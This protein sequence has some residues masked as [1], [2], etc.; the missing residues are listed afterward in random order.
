MCCR[1][2]QQQIGMKDQILIFFIKPT[3]NCTRTAI[4]LSSL[5][6]FQFSSRSIKV[7]HIFIHNSCHRYRKISFS[8]NALTRKFKKIS[9]SS[10]LLSVCP[11][12]FLQELF[13]KMYMNPSLSQEFESPTVLEKIDWPYYSPKPHAEM[14]RQKG[15]KPKAA[16][17]M[18]ICLLPSCPKLLKS[19]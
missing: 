7:L 17:Q 4:V 2:E 5:V 3:V 9:R 12:P 19:K 11:D 10:N 18:L 8:F 15:K 13:Y 14:G 6:K 1:E 16:S